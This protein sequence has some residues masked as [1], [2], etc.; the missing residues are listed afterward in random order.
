M[1]KRL[2]TP[3]VAKRLKVTRARI[4]HRLA[5]G[6][7]PNH[8]LCECGRTVMIPES[9][10]NLPIVDRRVG[11]PSWNAGTSKFKSRGRK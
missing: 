5:Q 6:H 3:E 11:N 1:I 10:L 4:T 2:T 7:F 8:A 9:D